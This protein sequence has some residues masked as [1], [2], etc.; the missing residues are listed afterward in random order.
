MDRD[1]INLAKRRSGKIFF[2]KN[3]NSPADL[4]RL[5]HSR[6]PVSVAKLTEA[7]ADEIVAVGT[8]SGPLYIGDIVADFL[9][10]RRV[11]T[12]PPRDLVTFFS[13]QMD[14][15]LRRV[16]STMIAE[17][18][19]DLPVCVQGSFWHHMDFSGKKAR[20]CDGQD[21]DASQ[22]I[23]QTQLGVV[24]MSPNVDDWPHDRVQRGAGSFALVLTNRQ[25][26]LSRKF[27]E[28]EDLTFDFNPESIKARVADAIAHPERYLEQA[29]AFGGRFREMYPREEFAN[30]VIDLAELATLLWNVPKPALQPFFSWPTR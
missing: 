24:D 30:R 5:W 4:R 7:M 25:G 14:D 6:L 27:P 19:L 2:L 13:A 17:S 16:K 3:G 23:L 15:Y 10:K 29:V 11:C 1:K 28:F 20:L 21:V 22:Q 9:Q 26:W 8:R 18:I 12:D